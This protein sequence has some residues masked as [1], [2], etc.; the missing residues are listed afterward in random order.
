MLSQ[1]ALLSLA[2][3]VP[4][5]AQGISTKS[6]L[7]SNGLSPNVD[8]DFWSALPS[9]PSEWPVDK[10]A[11]G[12]IPDTCYDFIANKGGVAY[13]NPYDVEVYNVK[14]PDVSRFSHEVRCSR[15]HEVVRYTLGSLPM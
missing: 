2:W 9:Q 6:L 15:T 8:S 11:W 3:A 13:C 4:S 7:F 10:W 1:S 5:L 12:Q 14:Y